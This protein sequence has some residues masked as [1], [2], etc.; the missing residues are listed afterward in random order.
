MSLRLSLRG[1]SSESID[2]LLQL[3]RQDERLWSGLA[4]HS[5][6]Q[7]SR[8]RVVRHE[9]PAQSQMSVPDWLKSLLLSATGRIPGA[10]EIVQKA[11][12]RLTRWSLTLTTE[13]GEKIIAHAYGTAIMDLGGTATDWEWEVSEDDLA[14]LVNA[15]ISDRPS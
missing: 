7:T 9:L 4:S 2:G 1:R 6:D 12:L 10:D 13:H 8:V 11:D 3:T 14:R 5:G 15:P